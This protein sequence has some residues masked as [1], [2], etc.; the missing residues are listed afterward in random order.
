MSITHPTG[1]FGALVAESYRVTRTD[2]AQ[3][4]EQYLRALKGECTDAEIAELEAGDLTD[5][6]VATTLVAAYEAQDPA[7]SSNGFYE[8]SP[9]TQVSDAALRTRIREAEE[10]LER[11]PKDSKSRSIRLDALVELAHRRKSETIRREA[12]QHRAATRERQRLIAVPGC[13]GWERLLN[14]LSEAAELVYEPEGETW[15]VTAIGETH[16]RLLIESQGGNAVT[17]GLELLA[18]IVSGYT[19]QECGSGASENYV[20][21]WPLRLC[22]TCMQAEHEHYRK[23]HQ[24]RGPDGELTEAARTLRHRGVGFAGV[25]RFAL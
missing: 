19:C 1:R 24:E 13:P 9:S 22:A 25:R 10:K 23:H 14:A 3:A 17:Q 2:P 21:V 5:V 8:P 18:H 12:L 20:G 7:E 15:Q 6:H 16:G 11:E 4:R